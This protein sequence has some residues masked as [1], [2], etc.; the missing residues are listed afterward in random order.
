MRSDISTPCGAR[1]NLSAPAHRVETALRQRGYTGAILELQ[2]STRSAAEAAEAVGCDVARIVKSLVFR[3][4]KGTPVLVLTSGANRVNE[5]G[6][7]DRLG[8]R[9]ARADADFVRQ[10]TGFAI[11]GVPP[12]AHATPLRTVID[13]DLMLHASVWAAAG[14]PNALFEVRPED[15]AKWCSA[16]I[17][18]IG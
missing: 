7:G 1:M 18:P 12:L 17:L 13:Q 16:E 11:G 8:E 4:E 2:Q 6:L 14:T 3:T 10:H 5:K 15:L 9:L